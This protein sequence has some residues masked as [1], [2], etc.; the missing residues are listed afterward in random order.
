MKSS[1]LRLKTL[2]L[3]VRKRAFEQVD[4]ASLVFFRVA[5]G[6]LMAIGHLEDERRDRPEIQ[7][8][9]M[10]LTEAKGRYRNQNAP[11]SCFRPL[12]ETECPDFALKPARELHE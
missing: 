1:L 5:F 11:A 7:R 3:N 2:L 10:P 8:I 6:L 4:I 12:S 9:S